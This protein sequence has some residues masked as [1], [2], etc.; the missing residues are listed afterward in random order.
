MNVSDSHHFRKTVA[1]WCMVAG[2]L[3]ALVSF[4]ISPKFETDE[5][6]QLAV[7]ADHSDRWYWSNLLGAVALVLLIGAV[8]GVM[9]ML[10]E[11]AVAYGHVGGAVAL[12][13]FCAA[14][15]TTGFAFVMWQMAKNGVTAGDVDLLKRLNDSNGLLPL[16]IATFGTAVGVIILA[17]GMYR[18]RVVDWWMAA[19]T[20][21]GVVLINI[22]FP[23]GALWLGI[24]GAA[25]LLVGLGSTGLMVL[26]ETDS[27]WE[28]T[29][30]FRG[31]RPA[32]G[33][34]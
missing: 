10:R 22:S 17:A 1:G 28:H 31:I 26:R 30:E 24:V 16:Y 11:R 20:A 5:A 15:V 3:V 9:H 18:A 7:V 4:V 33:T 29:P 23:A 13:G 12:V 32:T 2:P 21:L 34:G 25:V 6:K 19:M 27:D 8:L 14:L